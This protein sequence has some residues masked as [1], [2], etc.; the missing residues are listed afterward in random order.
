MYRIGTNIRVYGIE[1][2]CKPAWIKGLQGSTSQK[3]GIRL[4]MVGRYTH[5]IKEKQNERK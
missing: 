4:A 2:R 3:T 1:A 5:P